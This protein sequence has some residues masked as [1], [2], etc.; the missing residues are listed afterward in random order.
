KTTT[1]SFAGKIFDAD[2]NYSK[3]LFVCACE[4]GTARIFKIDE[5]LS[6][7][8]KIVISQVRLTSIF[9]EYKKSNSIISGDGNGILTVW[10]FETKRNISRLTT[11]VSDHKNDINSICVIEN[12]IITGNSVGHTSFW[13]ILTGTLLSSFKEHSGAVLAVAALTENGQNLVY[14]TGEDSKIALFF[15]TREELW[16]KRNVFSPLKHEIYSLAV[17]KQK[18]NLF[19][20][21]IEGILAITFPQNNLKN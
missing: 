11:N 17:N 4:D 15:K 1:N 9:W 13:D 6:Y 16:V 18:G 10:D 2:I 19:C 7:L 8:T 3:K 20:G 14:S 5:K 12:T 21:G